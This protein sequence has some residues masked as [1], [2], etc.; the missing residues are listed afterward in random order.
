[1]TPFYGTF[2][3]DNHV[4]RGLEEGLFGLVNSGTIKNLT[5]ESPT[6]KTGEY[7][8]S[9]VNEL[10]S[11]TIENCHVTNG[12]ISSNTGDAGG[13]VGLNDAGH[14]INCSVTSTT[15]TAQYYG[16]GIAGQM[17]AE[18]GETSITACRFSGT[19]IQSNTNSGGQ[20]G[21]IVGY[22]N[23][24]DSSVKA[25]YANCTLKATEPAQ[26][27]SMFTKA[28][29]VVGLLYGSVTACYAIA[30]V[31]N[32]PLTCGGVL[33]FQ[34]TLNSFNEP[35]DSEVSTCY[36]SGTDIT[37]GIGGTG[38]PGNASPDTATDENTTKVDNSTTT[39]STAMTAMNT[40]LNG[41]GWQYVENGSDTNFPL[42]IKAT[43]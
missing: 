20:I 15:I 34:A 43:E 21:G 14:I 26:G 6:A 17:T 22:A 35:V 42:V 29:G 3:G 4:I 1:M 36:W 9:F 8:G 37:H 28:G 7:V 10:Y 16:G 39:W 27:Y 32:N 5:L 19:I 18:Y 13:I 24:T 2:D 31:E 30:K 41:T 38:N 12:T 40:A 23:G 25:C 11:G 33:G